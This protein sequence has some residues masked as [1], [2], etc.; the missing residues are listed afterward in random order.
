MKYISK[1]P[2]LTLEF[3]D[4]YPDE[5]WN[6][7]HIS[8]NPRLTL[9]FIDRYPDKDW[10]WNYISANS[11]IYIH[12]INDNMDRPWD[13]NGIC[14]N[15]N[16]TFEF[17]DKHIDK[18]VAIHGYGNIVANKYTYQKQLFF[19]KKY[20]EHMASYKIQKWWITNILFNPIHPVGIEYQANKYKKEVLDDN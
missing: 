8:K 13:F 17:I 4:K 12:N 2:N 16:L 15:P 10:N 14:V 7:K 3:I 11:N 9:D 5:N 18:F 20:H 1:N 6:W 19:D